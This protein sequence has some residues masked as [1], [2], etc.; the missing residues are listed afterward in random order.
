ML[1]LPA[2]REYFDTGSYPKNPPEIK[3]PTKGQNT[4]E[5][6]SDLI[7]AFAVCLFMGNRLCRLGS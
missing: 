1:Y 4:D 6:K 7:P 5:K 2:A 3:G